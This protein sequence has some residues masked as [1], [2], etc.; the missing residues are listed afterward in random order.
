M[1]AGQAGKENPVGIV[2]KVGMAFP[3]MH[4]KTSPTLTRLEGEGLR[5]ISPSL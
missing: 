3:T 5:L 4:R 2:R 1:F